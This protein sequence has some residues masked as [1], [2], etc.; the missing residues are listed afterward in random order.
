MEYVLKQIDPGNH[1]PILISLHEDEMKIGRSTVTSLSKYNKV[2]RYHASFTKQNESWFVTDLQSMNCLYVN[3]ERIQ[4]TVRLNIGDIIGFGTPNVYSQD[5]GFVC[6]LLANPSKVTVKVEPSDDDDCVEIPTNSNI[7]IASTNPTIDE[8]S[9]VEGVSR[10]HVYNVNDESKMSNIGSITENL[11]SISSE[12]PGLKAYETESC[13]DLHL[14][15]NVHS[16][17]QA[18]TVQPVINCPANNTKK[19]DNLNRIESDTVS[20][21]RELIHV[22]PVSNSSDI[23]NTQ[24]EYDNSHSGDIIEHKHDA[25]KLGHPICTNTPSS[26][27]TVSPTTLAYPGI[28]YLEGLEEFRSYGTIDSKENFKNT[29]LEKCR[30]SNTRALPNFSHVQDSNKNAYL[31]SYNVKQDFPGDFITDFDAKIKVKPEKLE[32]IP[33]TPKDCITPIH[34]ATFNKCKTISDLDV[35]KSIPSTYNQLLE[36]LPKDCTQSFFGKTDSLPLPNDPAQLE[37]SY[38]SSQSLNTAS[39]SDKTIQVNNVTNNILSSYHH[40]NSTKNFKDKGY[41]KEITDGA[42]SVTE[43]RI[44]HT[45]KRKPSRLKNDNEVNPTEKTRESNDSIPTIQQDCSI[46]VKCDSKN[47]QISLNARETSS[48]Y[49]CTD[50]FYESSSE[51]PRVNNSTDESSKLKN[52]THQAKRSNLTVAI[53]LK[54]RKNKILSSESEGDEKNE[55]VFP[56]SKSSAKRRTEQNNEKPDRDNPASKRKKS[57]TG[58]YSP[59]NVSKETDKPNKAPIVRSKRRYSWSDSDEYYRSRSPPVNENRLQ[60]SKSLGRTLLIDCKPM[61]YRSRKLRGREEWFQERTGATNIKFVR[62]SRRK[63]INAKKSNW[64]SYETVNSVT[65]CSEKRKQKICCQ[66]REENK[67]SKYSVQESEENYSKKQKDSSHKMAEKDSE[68]NTEK[69]SVV[70]KRIMPP[71]PRRKINF[72]SRMGFLLDKQ[73]T[74]DDMKLINNDKQREELKKVKQDSAKHQ[75]I[76]SSESEF[77][78]DLSLE[79]GLSA[80]KKQTPTYKTKPVKQNSTKT[81]QHQRSIVQHPI[82]KVSKVPTDKHKPE[83]WVPILELDSKRKYGEQGNTCEERSLSDTFSDLNTLKTKSEIFQPK[84]I[85]YSPNSK[86]KDLMSPNHKTIKDSTK[87]LRSAKI[88]N[89]FRISSTSLT[90]MVVSWNPKWL[91]EQKNNKKPPPLIAQGA[92]CLNLSF[93]SYESYA[94][95]YFPMIVLEVWECLFKECSQHLVFEQLKNCNNFS[96]AIKTWED[97]QKLTELKCESI[98]SDTL[99]YHPTEGKIVLFNVKERQ[100]GGLENYTFGYIRRHSIEEFRPGA[101]EWDHIP[102]EAL[103]NAKLVKFE[104]VVKKSKRPSHLKPVYLAHGLSNIKQKLQMADALRSFRN[105]PLC[106]NIYHPREETL[107]FCD[108][109]R[110][111]LSWNNLNQVISEEVLNPL[112]KAQVMLLQTPPGTGQTERVVELVKKLT[113]VNSKKVKVLVCS[114][115]YTSLNELL[116]GLVQSNES[117]SNSSSASLMKLVRIGEEEGMS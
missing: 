74:C 5:G 101:P 83:K 47:T 25:H 51:L 42:K 31:S 23:T 112:S 49:I 14:S 66:K 22:N 20:E 38:D 85:N 53:N 108:S 1:S 48:P 15:V 96:Y 88:I 11:R 17:V 56:S 109:S 45:L 27:V 92:S 62:S 115:S 65:K 94:S 70:R 2:S 69:D 9:I 82:S 58:E 24:V 99:S 78:L 57:K 12:Q 13:F 59:I 84:D 50:N 104:V 106:E 54:V 61:E 32:S 34:S 91:V 40:C 21:P 68:K 76:M 55:I 75:E 87:C 64:K 10:Q 117:Y 16:K 41:S 19:D 98:V 110:K 39:F 93:S 71:V 77:Q 114:P 102:T 113:S 52:T 29:D 33:D 95:S 81:T 97:K 44:H 35:K 43:Q 8:P 60:E 28:E 67:E 90:E 6:F 103:N 4:H 7:N 73:V 26:L 89:K 79:L 3:E 105:S 80:N 72:C 30:D 18:C 116:C 63:S 37:K 36:H 107:M 46:Q 100:E 86:K 111:A